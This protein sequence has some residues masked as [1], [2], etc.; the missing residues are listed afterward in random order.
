MCQSHTGRL[1]ELWFLPKPAFGLN[2]TNNNKYYDI[3]LRILVSVFFCLNHCI[4]LQI[5]IRCISCWT[6]WPFKIGP[7]G[8]TETSATNDLFRLHKIQKSADL[9]CKWNWY[10]LCVS[11][12]RFGC[13]YTVDRFFDKKKIQQDGTTCG[14]SLL[15]EGRLVTSPSVG[16]NIVF[17]RRPAPFVAA[18]S[19]VAGTNTSVD[20]FMHDEMVSAFMKLH[21]FQWNEE[22]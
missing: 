16:K 4:T 15:Q 3:F 22:C 1:T 14:Q 13:P 21:L 19:C 7:T 18:D 17:R 2:T 12:I 10:K 6:A 8:W 20:C 11:V 9:S 5:T